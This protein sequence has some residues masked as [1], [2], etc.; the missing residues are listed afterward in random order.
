MARSAWRQKH[1]PG[2]YIARE[3]INMLV[4]A[5]SFEEFDMFV[6]PREG[7]DEYLLAYF[8]ATAVGP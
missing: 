7:E 2:K 5:G 4:D 1:Q 3:Q 8:V 6:A